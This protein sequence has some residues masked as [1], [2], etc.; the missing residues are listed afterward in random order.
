MKKTLTMN[1]GGRVFHIDE[2][3]YHL[4]DD[5]LHSLAAHFDRDNRT[6]C[7][8]IEEFEVYFADAVTARLQNEQSVIDISMVR[9]VIK[10]SNSAAYFSDEGYQS[11]SD[12]S[13]HNGGEESRYSGTP[14][15]DEAADGSAKRKF[16]RDMDNATLCGVCSGLAAYTGWNVAVVRII[17][18]L[19]ALP[20]YSI[21][22]LVIVGY[23]AVWMI[24][25]PAITA[26]Q[27]LQ[28]HGEPITVENIGRRVAAD[29]DAALR[30]RENGV[31]NAL[32]CLLKGVFVL[33]GVGLILAVV[34]GLFGL[35][36]ELVAG[37]YVSNT[38]LASEWVSIPSW[39]V[40]CA[41]AS[42]FVIVVVPVM[43][44]IFTNHSRDKRGSFPSGLRWSALGLWISAVILLIVVFVLMT[45]EL[46]LTIFLRHAA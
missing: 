44:I 1:L 10:S 29:A 13:H 46:G 38:P 45:R 35:L 26:S 24:V 18:V 40:L 15:F 6:D 32:G 7:K 25:P 12:Y 31:V 33:A 14:D 2:D 9:E 41:I 42:V 30:H 21:S 5:Y 36:M 43:A 27:K 20:V 37:S 23:L 4:L 3:A 8:T 39:M 16:F 28:M 22:W 34:F 19:L 11:T 17:V